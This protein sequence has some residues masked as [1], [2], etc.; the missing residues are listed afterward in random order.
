VSQALAG[1]RQWRRLIGNAT[2]GWQIK[3]LLDQV[4]LAVQGGVSIDHGPDVP[5]SSS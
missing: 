2:N 1:S 3:A 4:G 5:A